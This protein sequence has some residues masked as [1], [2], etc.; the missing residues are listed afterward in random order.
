MKMPSNMTEK[1]VV[2]VIAKVSSSL[3][4][5]FKFG[6]FGIDDMR[7]QA[8]LFALQ[9]M[10]KYDENRPL[11]NFLYR[12]VKNR[13]INFKRD[14]LRRSDAPC[15]DCHN[16]ID[17]H[18]KHPDGAYCDK[19]ISW[20]RRNTSKQNIMNAVDITNINDENESRTRIE[21]SVVEDVA[22]AELLKLIGQKLPLELRATYLQMQADATKVPINKRREVQRV[23]L[24][25]LEEA[26]VC[27]TNE[28]Q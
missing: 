7:Q 17:G 21:S 12:H 8:T 5:K 9:G 19:Y 25:I 6:Y 15:L 18:T 3:A 14:K 13:L 4:K 10:E 26:D 2:D 28:D 16:A 11:E 24:Q 27:L 20:Q 1:E 22:N 23:I